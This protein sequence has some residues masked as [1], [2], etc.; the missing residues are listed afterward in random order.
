[1]IDQPPSDSHIKVIGV[2]GAGGMVINRLID[3]RIRGLD[4]LVVDTAFQGL[5]H[6]KAKLR[7][8]L[9]RN[10]LNGLGTGGEIEQGKIAAEAS[11]DD[12][13][14][15]LR[16]ADTVCLVAGMGGG[17]GGGASPVIARVAR[18]HA[19]RIIGIASRPFTFEGSW[20]QRAA[21]ES[22]ARLRDQVDELIE[23]DNN[24]LLRLAGKAPDPQR[25]YDLAAGV[26]AWQVITHVV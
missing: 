17:T 26:L 25:V 19:T 13:Y 4:L 23:F 15:V 7:V 8:Q 24:R 20:R 3:E 2:G 14:E 1:M 22:L 21:D 6:S 16:A 5:L 10:L 11:T 9:G 18:E 12:L